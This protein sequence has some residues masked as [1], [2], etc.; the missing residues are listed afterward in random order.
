M[1]PWAQRVP[2]RVPQTGAATAGATGG[3]R[4]CPAGPKTSGPSRKR[5]PTPLSGS[6]QL[7]LV[8]LKAGMA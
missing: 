6:K 5:P 7:V 1:V 4:E 2:Q 3:A 8:Q